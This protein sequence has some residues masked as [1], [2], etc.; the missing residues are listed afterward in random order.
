MKEFGF[1]KKTPKLVLKI[2]LKLTKKEMI[3]YESFY[4]HTICQFYAGDRI[5]NGEEWLGFMT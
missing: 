5:V 2:M 4:R 1:S 3:I